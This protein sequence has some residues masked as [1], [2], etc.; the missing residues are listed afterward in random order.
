MTVT[1]YPGPS[2]PILSVAEWNDMFRYFLRPGVIDVGNT[3]EN[4]NKFE[5]YADSTGMQV[6]VKSGK[7][8]IQGQFVKNDAEAT[9]AISAADATNGRIDYIVIERD[10]TLTPPARLL[11]LTGTPHATP[12]TGAPTLTQTD[13]GI[14]QLKLAEV[15]I[16]AAA[17]TIAAGKVTD[18]RT[19]ATAL[20]A[21]YG[22]ESEAG[23]TGSGAP[24]TTSTSYTD[25]PDMTA[26]VTLS[27]AGTVELRWCGDIASSIAGNYIQIGCQI[28]GGAN[29]LLGTFVAP[30]ANQVDLKSAFHRFT[31]LAAGTHTVKVRW[32]VQ[33]GSTGTVGANREI[34][35]RAYRS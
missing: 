26:T 28:D 18:G 15:L 22:V 34:L 10:T 23:A 16:D 30:Y 11:V 17:S 9:L 1:A 3:S 29:I 21:R 31:G 13:T 19:Y 32:L 35:A 25:M 27:G 12:A 7:A 33:S 24:T 2:S 14:Y 8:F 20:V 4:L 6:K 5:V